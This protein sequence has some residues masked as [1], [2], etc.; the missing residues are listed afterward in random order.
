VTF[1]QIF[2]GRM[3]LLSAMRHI[4]QQHGCYPQG[5]LHF[6]TGAGGEAFRIVERC[7][8]ELEREFNAKRSRR[9]TSAARAA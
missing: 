6:R 5:K 4:A 3:R 8:A 7:I 2:S 1:E 9:K